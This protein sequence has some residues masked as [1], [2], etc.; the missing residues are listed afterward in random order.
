MSFA[1]RGIALVVVLWTVTLLAVIAGNFAYTLRI[2]STLA[3]N[4]VGRAKA[5]ALAEAGVVYAALDLLRPL[6]MRRFSP[7]GIPYRWKFGGETVRVS[8][9]DVGG[10]IDLNTASR[11]LLGGLLG[12]AGVAEEERDPLLDAIEDWRDPDDVPRLQGAEDEDY[13]A[14][15]LPYGAKD[16]PF[17]DITELQQ[18]LGVSLELYQRIEEFL[19]LYSEQSGIDPAVAPRG[20]LLAI[21]GIDFELIEIYL[22]ERRV[23]RA[24]GEAPPPLPPVGGGYLAQAGG[25]AYSVRAEA[26]T[27]GGGA[28]MIEAVISPGSSTSGSLPYSV[29][30]WRE[31][32]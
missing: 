2:E 26:K 12:A 30:E 23:R 13:L 16:G 6:Q 22:E 7:D 19:T 25:L 4:L 27:E 5:R 8:V 10:L 32:L 31:S 9:R 21:P 20:V 14:A 15:G 24:L 29:L 28:A 18:V 1:E 3:A 17:E 11:E